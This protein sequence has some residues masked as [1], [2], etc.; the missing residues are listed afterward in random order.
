MEGKNGTA[1]LLASHE[2]TPERNFNGARVVRTRIG[3][4]HFSILMIRGAEA[5]F[6]EDGQ[7]MMKLPLLRSFSAAFSPRSVLQIRT[8]EGKLIENNP[9]FCRKCFQNTGVVVEK[10]GINPFGGTIRILHCS[11]CNNKWK[12]S[13]NAFRC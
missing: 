6:L 1:F 8:L 11:A 4:N 2:W 5:F 13:G 7:V 3:K 12:V 10:P 9:L